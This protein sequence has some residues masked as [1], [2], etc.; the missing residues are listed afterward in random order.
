L[1]VLA[2]EDHGH[3]ED[4]GEIQSFVKISFGSCAVAHVAHHGDLIAL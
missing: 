3:A 1:V 2:Y 4:A